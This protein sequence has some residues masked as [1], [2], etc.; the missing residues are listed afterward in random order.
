MNKLQITE[1]EEYRESSFPRA[2]LGSTGLRKRFPRQR[3]HLA[4]HTAFVR[5][6]VEFAALLVV[7]LSVITI[8]QAARNGSARLGEPRR[9]K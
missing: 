4:V 6:S 5:G 8:P 9:S 2:C 3:Y 7:L 1:V